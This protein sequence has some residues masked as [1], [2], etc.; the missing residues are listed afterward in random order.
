MWGD[1]MILSKKLVEIEDAMLWHRYRES[2]IPEWILTLWELRMVW[3]TRQHNQTRCW[4]SP[5]PKAF[6]GTH[7]RCK[8]WRWRS[9]RRI[10]VQLRCRILPSRSNLRLCSR[11]RHGAPSWYERQKEEFRA[12]SY[13][14]SRKE[15]P[16]R[17]SNREQSRIGTWFLAVQ[18][19]SLRQH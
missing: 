15:G 8:R 13:P 11:L 5:C 3:H 17:R 16:E 18:H 1:G 9:L 2:L 6:E 7:R 14:H 12:C 4:Q 10:R 19:L